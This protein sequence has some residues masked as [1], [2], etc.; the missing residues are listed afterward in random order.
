MKQQEYRLPYHLGVE[1]FMTAL[2]HWG[3]AVFNGRH[4]T[5]KTYY[6]SF[7]WR[8]YRNDLIG[9]WL[10]SPAVSEWRL[11]TVADRDTLAVE[12][13][14]KVPNSADDFADAAMVGR[15]GKILGNRALIAL[16]ELDFTQYQWQ[17]K[18]GR[19]KS[20]GRLYLELHEVIP[21]RLIVCPDDGFNAIDHDWQGFCAR[22]EL[23]PER[24]SVLVDALKLQGRKPLDYASK[25]LLPLS[26]DTR[27]DLAVKQIFKALLDTLKRNEQGVIERT[28][29]EFLHDYRVAVRRTRSGLGQLKGVLPKVECRRFAKMFAELGKITN[30]PRDLDVYLE[31][32]EDLRR[33]VTEDMRPDLQPVLA[34][35]ESRHQI[36][37]Q[38]LTDLLKSRNYHENMLAWETFLNSATVKQPSEP[39]ALWPIKKLADRR[40]YQTYQEVIL[41]GCAIDRQSPPEQLHELRKT[42]KKLRYLL[43][44]FQTL[45]DADTLNVL[46]KK[47]KK[48]QDV[49]G[50]Y[51]DLQVQEQ[52]LT[53]FSQELAKQPHSTD[54]LLA[55]G[56]L[57]HA[58]KGRRRSYREDFQ[59]RFDAFHH[60][61]VD[62]LF[63]EAFKRAE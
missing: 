30:P 40:I 54:T 49:L 33:Q 56:A 19:H 4:Y 9:F 13:C 35:I 23:T 36:A 34:L 22:F 26:A 42:C 24:D 12:P 46:I 21:S 51:Q 29:A 7:D 28:D 47:L 25:F 18:D 11:E 57:I 63:V 5:V 45:Y 41:E 61:D 59:E 48:L 14:Q 15:L 3:H 16:T 53:V 1:K 39:K 20:I 50:G 17:F 43:E 38:Q 31:Q 32:F 27:A 62:A 60:P 55:I 37:Y 8:L 44:F 2:E 58:L 10:R 6:D 52:T